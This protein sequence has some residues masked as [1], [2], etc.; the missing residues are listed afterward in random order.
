MLCKIV[1]YFNVT[2]EENTTGTNH[3]KVALI[4]WK[5]SGIHDSCV[6]PTGKG[7]RKVHPRTGHEGP[8]GE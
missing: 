6:P 3:L 8:E 1:V 4:F 5:L 7:K 2:S